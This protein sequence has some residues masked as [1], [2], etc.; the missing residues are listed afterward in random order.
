MFYLIPCN[1]SWFIKN[2][3]SYSIAFVLINTSAVQ[4]LSVFNSLRLFGVSAKVAW[5]R[6]EISI[7]S[8]YLYDSLNGPIF[9]LYISVSSFDQC[10]KWLLYILSLAV[11][12]RKS[13]A[14]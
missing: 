11:I 10:L 9:L 8:F 4:G 13:I 3:Q 14:L 5:I 7:V 6:S 1:V 12:L 2:Q